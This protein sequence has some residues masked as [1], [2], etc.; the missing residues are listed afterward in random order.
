ESWRS[1]ER[2]KTLE[3]MLAQ[4]HG[5]KLEHMNKEDP[6]AIRMQYQAGFQDMEVMKVPLI[7]FDESLDQLQCAFLDCPD[8]QIHRL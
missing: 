3:K 6:E 5:S 8:V 2:W 4:V 7:G 1:G